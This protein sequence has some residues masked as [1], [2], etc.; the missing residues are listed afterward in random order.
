MAQRERRR[1][2]LGG[3]VVALMVVGLG[4]LT[5]GAKPVPTDT[6]LL[7]AAAG[8]PVTVATPPTRPRS[9]TTSTTSTTTTTTTAPAPTA[10]PTT[11]AA[12]ADAPS[13]TAPVVDPAPPP[14]EPDPTVPPP[15]P[16]PPPPSGGVL[17]IG[18]SV[19]V[20]ASNALSNEYGG[21][22]AIDARVS[23][24]V[25]EG[26][27]ALRAWV[28][29]GA[30]STIVIHLG[31]NGPLY[32]DQFDQIM[33]IAGPDRIVVFVTVHVP[34]S[35]E[36]QSNGAIY[37]GATRY[38]NVRLVDWRAMVQDNPAYVGSDG[39]HCTA[40]GAAAL[41]SAVHQTTG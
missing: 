7:I 25:N 18:D 20:G 17:A 38:G 34:R 12:P 3:A 5:V 35:W 6:E 22:I 10:P 14:S 24:Q 41:A 13:E 29:S 30:P 39:I 36:D 9:T 27:A 28:D 4:S 2:L 16:T 37:D 23:R 32:A 33:S 31:S 11:E 19:F 26:I 40:A 15:P 8:P 1:W 21:N